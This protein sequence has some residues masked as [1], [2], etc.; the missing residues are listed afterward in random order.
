MVH[1]KR[2]KMNDL[3]QECQKSFREIYDGLPERSTVK[4]P[5]TE[6]VERIA[7]LTMKSVKTVRCWLAGVQTPDALSKSVIEKELNIPSEILFP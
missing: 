1:T 7:E 2:K 6:F 4:A 3:T 5:K